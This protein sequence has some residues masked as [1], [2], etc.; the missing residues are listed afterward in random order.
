MG[1]IKVVTVQNFKLSLKSYTNLQ[2]GSLW[3]P[4]MLEKKVRFCQF[5]NQFFLG[6]YYCNECQQCCFSKHML[7]WSLWHSFSQWKSFYRMS[8]PYCLSVPYYHHVSHNCK[9]IYI[10]LEALQFTLS[11]YLLFTRLLGGLL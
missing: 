10:Y 2:G 4:K 7:L 1:L 8:T 3:R 11:I 9:Q 5:C 6:K